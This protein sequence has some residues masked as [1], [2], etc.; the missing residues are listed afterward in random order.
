MRVF[1]FVL[2]SV[3]GANSA[4]AQS[5]ALERATAAKRALTQCEDKAVKDK[6]AGSAFVARLGVCISQFRLA[7]D[8]EAA[9]MA[10]RVAALGGRMASAEGALVG[11]SGRVAEVEKRAVRHDHQITAVTDRVGD[12]L[13]NAP[14]AKLVAGSVNHEGGVAGAFGVGLSLPVAKGEW[15]AEMEALGSV[16]NKSLGFGDDSIGL[17]LIGRGTTFVSN[18]WD[19]PLVGGPNLRY[20]VDGPKLSR[21][22]SAMFAG[23]GLSAGWQDGR[24]G[25]IADGSFGFKLRRRGDDAHPAWVSGLLAQVKF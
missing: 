21:S 20:Q 3:M 15:L 8:L 24:F 18:P 25:V 19:F 5:S 7:R 12:L 11:M 14:R 10:G 6:K 2:A 17:T 1:L 22:P 23:A 9:L 16:R 13:E 4:F